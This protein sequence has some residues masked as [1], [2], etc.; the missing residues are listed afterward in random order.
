M[1]DHVLLDESMWEGLLV[2]KYMEVINLV[3]KFFFYYEETRG[4][5]TFVLKM[6]DITAVHKHDVDLPRNH[7]KINFG[8]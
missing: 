2:R 5:H 8:K 3:V 7:K 6:K 4:L 1:K